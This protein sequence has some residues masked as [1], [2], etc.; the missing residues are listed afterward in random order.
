MTDKER[1]EEI[2]ENANT[3]KLHDFIT[4]L[5][6]EDYLW[7]IELVELHYATNQ[8]IEQNLAGLQTTLQKMNTGRWGES[9]IKIANDLIKQQAGRIET[10][11]NKYLALRNIHNITLKTGELV[12]EENKR[13]KQAMQNAINA[14]RYTNPEVAYILSEALEGEE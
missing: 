3:Y 2:K 7:L 6:Y 1:L 12:A 14:C 5:P 9:I 13:Y 4:E 8:Q 10:L 11:E